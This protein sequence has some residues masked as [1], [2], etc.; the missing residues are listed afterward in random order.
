MSCVLVMQVLSEMCEELRGSLE[1]CKLE[2][3]ANANRAS[4]DY[5]QAQAQAMQGKLE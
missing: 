2:L 5:L 4:L 1:Q 3:T